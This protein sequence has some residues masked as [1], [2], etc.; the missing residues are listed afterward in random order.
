[1]GIEDDLAHMRE[2]TAGWR[3]SAVERILARYGFELK[4]QRG[5]DRVYKHEPSGRRYF[6]SWHGSG[7]VKRGYI[8]EL[9]RAIDDT[10]SLGE[11]S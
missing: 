9:V 2:H 4:N 10:R 5:S 7:D 1:M 6:I 11:K 3:F 8:K